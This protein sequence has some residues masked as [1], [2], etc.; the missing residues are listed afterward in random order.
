MEAPRSATTRVAVVT[1]ASQG[2]GRAIADHLVATG[3]LVWTVARRG[4]L[5]ADLAARHSSG[6]MIPAPADLTHPA[7]IDHLIMRI[8]CRTPQVHALIHSAGTY[9]YGAMDTLPA[10]Q[11]RENYAVNVESAYLL[12]QKLLG[13]MPDPADIIFLNSSQGLRAAATVSQFAAS[14]HSRKALAD[15]LRAEVNER[16]IRV[17]SLFLGRTASPLQEGIYKA[18]GW[19]YEPKLLLQPEEVATMVGTVLAMPRTAEVTDITMRPA[20]KSY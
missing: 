13:L 10:V 17:T 11:L 15:A 3:F 9:S 14:M 5:L 20:I 1:G 16:A 12:T 19:S 6:M 8:R 2:I 18:H 4:E 7:E